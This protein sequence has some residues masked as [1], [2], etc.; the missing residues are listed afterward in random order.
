[1]NI[2]RIKVVGLGFAFTML[3]MVGVLETA[4]FRMHQIQKH[5]SAVSTVHLEKMRHVSAMREGTFERILLSRKLLHTRDRFGAEELAQ[6]FYAARRPVEEAFAALQDLPLTDAERTAVD[7]FLRAA[8]ATAPKLNKVVND[9]IGGKSANDIGADIVD[10]FESQENVIRALKTTHDSVYGAVQSD[11]EGAAQRYHNTR[12]LIIAMT[13]VAVF[14]AALITLYV[15]RVMERQ[16]REI[17]GERANYRNLFTSMFDPA[18]VVEEGRIVDANIPFHEIFG[19]DDNSNALA[20]ADQL[21]GSDPALAATWQQHLQQA[22]TDGRHYFDWSFALPTGGQFDGEVAATRVGNPSR[23]ILLVIRDVTRQRQ[24]LNRLSYQASHDP[25]TGL[26][27]RRK[28]RRHAAELLEQ[29]RAD[30][31]QHGLAYI[32]LDHFKAINDACGHEAGD[33]LLAEIA[34]V[35]EG[36]IR[37]SDLLARLGGDEFGLLLENCPV[38]RATSIAEDICTAVGN[39][40]FSCSGRDFTVGASIGIAPITDA[41]QSIDDVIAAADKACYESKRRGRGLVKVAGT[42]EANGANAPSERG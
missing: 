30:A 7:D 33:K 25:L 12:N 9:Y 20:T 39:H 15:I 32:D 14:C 31:M 41:S 21:S 4:A 6:E 10:A 19:D 13:V 37:T 2:Q 27:N 29:T 35:I 22:L 8:Q 42:F 11:I 23:R 18:V 5:F 28:F 34:R 40:R 3:L 38:S 26:S 1:L 17:E 36:K 24:L 16:T